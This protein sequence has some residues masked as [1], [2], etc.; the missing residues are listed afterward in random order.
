MVSIQRMAHRI[1]LSLLTIALILLLSTHV[2]AETPEAQEVLQKMVQSFQTENFRGRL[3]FMSLTPDGGQMREALMTRKAPDKVRIELLTPV[4]ERGTVIVM[5]GEERWHI[6]AK[7][8]QFR[9]RRRQRFRPPDRMGEILM[10]DAQLLLQNY[11]IQVFE[12]GHVAGRSAYLIEVKSE[13]AVRPSANL[14]V[15]TEAGVILK[16]EHYDPQKRLRDILAYSQIELNPEIDEAIFQRPEGVNPDAGPQGGRGREEIW[17]KGQGELDLRKLRKA[18]GL[19]VI[20][21]GLKPAGFMLQS[22]QIVQFGER[23]NV[24]LNYTDGLAVISVFESKSNGGLRGGRRGRGPEGRRGGGNADLP[25][26]RGGGIEKVDIHGIACDVMSR[27]PMS[28]FRWKQKEIYITL[29]S[30]LERKEMTKIAG[31]F[32]N[33]GK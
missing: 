28:I 16:M 1:W 24:H 12:G 18:A 7:R 14:W 2:G 19:N 3:I 9:E 25:Q 15:D 32:I 17:S 23:K 21:P 26:R 31:L 6:G 10:K 8:E 33:D 27:G 30:E 13:A 4:E 22:V 29:M 11:D 5:N 20:V